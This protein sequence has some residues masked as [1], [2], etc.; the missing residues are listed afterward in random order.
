MR[1]LFRSKHED[2]GFQR[3]VIRQTRKH[4]YSL[5]NTLMER[6]YLACENTAGQAGSLKNH[7]TKHRACL[8]SPLIL[9]SIA[10]RIQIWTQFL[11]IWM[12][13]FDKMKVT[14]IIIILYMYELDPL[15]RTRKNFKEYSRNKLLFNTYRKYTRTWMWTPT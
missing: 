8:Y 4:I 1:S 7:R 10:P 9:F 13:N 12:N 14:S 11:E 3:K 2:L 15:A 5:F 6:R